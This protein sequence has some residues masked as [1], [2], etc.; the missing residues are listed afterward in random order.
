[1]RG[2]DDRDLRAV[3]ARA[4]HDFFQ[5]W[6]SGR[7]FRIESG[8]GGGVSGR[9]VTRRGVTFGGS[10][11]FVQLLVFLQAGVVETVMLNGVRT[12]RSNDLP[13]N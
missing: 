5:G 7:C 10:S 6:V 11:A 8:C 3:A 1:M 2:R 4:P 12:N 13:N 9:F